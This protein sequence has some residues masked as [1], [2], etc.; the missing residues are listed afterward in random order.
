MKEEVNRE[1]SK[2]VEDN[3][4]LIYKPVRNYWNANEM[5]RRK[6]EF[7]ELLS[8]ATIALNE[9]A[10]KFDRTKGFEFSTYAVPLIQYALIAHTRKDRWYYRRRIVNGV[11]KFE[12]VDRVSTSAKVKNVSDY[13]DKDITVEDSLEDMKDN[14]K[15]IEDKYIVEHLLATC[16]EREKDILK[17]YFYG[18][19]SQAQLSK[20][21]KTSQSYISLVI[22]RNLKRF[23]QILEEG[24]TRK[25]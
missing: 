25:C 9:A 6:Y 10:K 3:I 17:G 1:I 14:Y 24:E 15:D 7:D 4:K 18:E 11:E 21:F 22:K 8:V 13:G 19:K 2:M 20:E 5:V 12:L 16:V 23:K